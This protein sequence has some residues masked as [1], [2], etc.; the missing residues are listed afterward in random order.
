MEEDA[1]RQGHPAPDESN[2]RQKH[3]CREAAFPDLETLKD[4]FRFYAASSCGRILEKMTS[5]SLVSMAECF[6]AGFSDATGTPTISEDRTEI[7]RVSTFLGHLKNPHLIIHQWIRI[8]L[9]KEGAVVNASK[10][11]YNFGVDDLDRILITLWTTDDLSFLH[12]RYRLQFTYIIREF[13]WTG[14]RI[15]AFFTGGLRYQVSFG[16]CSL[17]GFTD[18]EGCRPRP[19]AC[20]WFSLE[21]DLSDQA[22]MGQ[23]QPRP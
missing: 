6:F 19:A 8:T 14:A 1:V 15:G 10:P 4:F 16:A 21:I 17:D 2:A 12:E 5:D 9:V 11:K 23:R 7:Y 3:L 18:S 13:C 22:T 20:A